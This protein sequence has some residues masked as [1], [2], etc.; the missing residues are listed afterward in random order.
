MNQSEIGTDAGT[1]QMCIR[2]RD[3][4][5]VLASETGKYTI[6]V[7]GTKGEEIWKTLCQN[8]PVLDIQYKNLNST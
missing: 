8:N 3:G 1:I 4:N 2:D 7:K 5:Y 6:T